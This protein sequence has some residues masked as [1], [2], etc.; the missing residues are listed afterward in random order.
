MCDNFLKEVYPLT[1]VSD[2]YGGT[3]SGAEFLAFNL[4]PERIPKDIGGS[5]SEEMDFWEDPERYGA[6]VIGKGD[7][8]DKAA[9]DLLDKIH[10]DRAIM[11]K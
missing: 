11:S 9:F 3:Y 4:E 10:K 1:I 2:R 5:D 6:Y 7:T 8:P